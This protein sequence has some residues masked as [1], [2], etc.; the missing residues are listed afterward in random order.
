MKV[1]AVIF[2]MFGVLC[3]TTSPELCIIKEYGL[4]PNIHDCMQ[5]AVCGYRFTGDWDAYIHQ[6]IEAAEIDDNDIFR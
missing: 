3:C 5:R 2:D 6:I 4:D 1:R